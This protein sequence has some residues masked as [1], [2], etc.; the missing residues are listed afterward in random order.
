MRAR[1]R[2]TACCFSPRRPVSGAKFR[3]ERY[4]T[5]PGQGPDHGEPHQT[6]EPGRLPEAGQK[7]EVEGRRDLIPNALV[8]ARADLEVIA[9]G[10]HVVVIGGAARIGVHPLRIHRIQFISKTVFLRILK[11]EARVAESSSPRPRGSRMG[12]APESCDHAGPALPSTCGVV[13][14]LRTCLLSSICSMA[15]GGGTSLS[16]MLGLTATRPLVVGNHNRPCPGFSTRLVG[17]RH[18]IA[19]CS[20][21]PFY[22]RQPHGGTRSSFRRAPQSRFY[23]REIGLPDN[24]SKNSRNHLPAIETT[25]RVKRRGHPWRCNT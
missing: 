16:P 24:S 3:T 19:R 20:N 8:I 18:C 9:A 11:A 22:Y 2:A 4:R 13:P 14:K 21:R 25:S 10:G 15:T 23:G 5:V 1:S 7:F 12:R 6:A 17:R